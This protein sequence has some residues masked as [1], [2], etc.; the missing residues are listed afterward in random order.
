M[1]KKDKKKDKKS[2]AEVVEDQ[3]EE[4]QI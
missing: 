1:K 2:K 4:P 3:K